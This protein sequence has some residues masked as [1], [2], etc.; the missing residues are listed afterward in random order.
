MLAPCGPSQVA[1]RAVPIGKLGSNHSTIRSLRQVSASIIAAGIPSRSCRDGHSSSGMT[2]AEAR[3]SLRVGG[4]RTS[5]LSVDQ[6]KGVGRAYGSADPPIRTPPFRAG[7]GTAAAAPGTLKER[8]AAYERARPC[9][10]RARSAWQVR[11]RHLRPL[12]HRFLHRQDHH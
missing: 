10:S 7:A 11:E 12:G 1:D 6:R 8:T 4:V 9:P 3:N 5:R 2:H